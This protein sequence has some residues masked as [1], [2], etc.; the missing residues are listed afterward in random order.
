[1]TSTTSLQQ[2]NIAELEE[3]L[4]EET[5]KFTSAFHDGTSQDQKD[6]I[7][8]RIDDIQQLLEK[9]KQENANPGIN[10]DENTTPDMR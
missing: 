3:L 1:M 6:I 2:L 8:K 10:A 4:M 5:K 9:R 7:R